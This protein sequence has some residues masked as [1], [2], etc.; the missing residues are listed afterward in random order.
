M[1]RQSRVLAVCLALSVLPA[2]AGLCA[3]GIIPSGGDYLAVTGPCQLILGGSGSI[4]TSGESLV[5]A[6]LPSSLVVRDGRSG[7]L[8]VTLGLISVSF[9]AGVLSYTYQDS[10]AIM[11][12]VQSFRSTPLAVRCR[13]DITNRSAFQLWLCPELRLPLYHTAT[14]LN[15]WDGFEKRSAFS[16]QYTNAGFGGVFPAAAVYGSSSGVLL[17]ICAD[18]I[19]SYI[20]NS[21]D[22]PSAKVLSYGVK[23][24]IDAGDTGSVEYVIAGFRPSYGYLDAVDVYYRE[25]PAQFSP[26]EGINPRVVG[27]THAIGAHD[28]AL[29]QE[30]GN[31][32]SSNS[33][34]DPYRRTDGGITWWYAPFKKCGDYYCT[35]EEW[36][37]PLE[38]ESLVNPPFTWTTE[39]YQ[40]IR[41]RTGER[42]SRRDLAYMFYITD[43]CEKDLAYRRYEDQILRKS[44]G[45]H[46][47]IYP[48]VQSFTADLAMWW[49]GQFGED[50]RRD[51]Q[52]IAND[53]DI[54]GFAFDV[55]DQCMLD[56][57]R[58][59][60]RESNGNVLS[61]FP[62]RAY[63]AD[64]VF[65]DESVARAV[66]MDYVHT[67]TGDG[68]KMATWPNLFN[69]Y[70]YFVAFRSDS[71]LMELTN[72]ELSYWHYPYHLKSR[73]L[74]GRK[75]R[76]FCGLASREDLDG[77]PPFTGW[78]DATAE[79][80]RGWY[81]D[82]WADTAVICLQFGYYPGTAH[83][84]GLCRPDQGH[85]HN[86]QAHTSGLGTRPGL[87]GEYFR[88]RHRDFTLRQGHQHIPVPGKSRRGRLQPAADN[89]QRVPGRRLL[90]VLEYGRLSACERNYPESDAP[91]DAHGGTQGV[92][93]IQGSGLA[94][95]HSA[96]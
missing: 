34:Y 86:I 3:D 67:L 30:A 33:S 8:P 25:F 83:H 68:K 62:G 74:L 35:Q 77:L 32:D 81:R 72:G 43:W 87:Q 58:L 84:V 41:R 91:A 48:W 44:D 31:A 93:G 61:G 92:S 76:Q 73:P 63:D 5:S 15:Y 45:S 55:A 90:C 85:S 59:R 20:E 78:A 64:G 16:G 79:T 54:R 26:E 1:M 65:C 82:L 89:R 46:Y 47:E 88:S 49:G 27:T 70:A 21:L 71:V 14:T 7:D 66:M 38:H 39:Q 60:A 95:D 12:I 37:I 36:S 56:A 40:D 19:F 17:G 29:G 9:S 13:L 24:I 42:G 6:T 22:F 75:P 69:T 96:A 52:L 50:T 94:G 23:T 80:I 2:A 28:I 10:G 51:L 57:N 11:T 18:Q 53:L 4:R